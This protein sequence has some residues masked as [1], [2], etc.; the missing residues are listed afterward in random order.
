MPPELAKLLAMLLPLIGAAGA[1]DP[2]LNLPKEFALKAG[3]QIV[4]IGDS[5]TAQGGYLRDVDAVLSAR[6]PELKLPPIVGV[7]IGGQKAED[8]VK[9][10]R[11]DVI[12]R[13]PAVVTISIG[14][15]DVW[16]RMKKPHDPFVA[17]EY[18]AN[19]D[20][21]VAMSQA[22]GIRTILLTPT[23]IGE[24][25]ES[26]ENR[27]LRVYVEAEKQVARERGCALVDL[28]RI[29][30]AALP[31]RPEGVEGKNWLTKDGVHM[32]PPGDA[33]MAIGVL[34]ALGMPDAEIG[35]DDEPGPSAQP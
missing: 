15:N 4:A 35:K 5:I 17:A 13:H 25:P 18:W 6:H 3:D 23:V 29:F 7:G 27:R 2:D 24:D 31:K 1:S 28:H 9:R 16:H 8:L 22:A 34:R 19:V 11:K 32:A 20:R 33:L 12:D 14:V 10:F 21:L 30:V 26:P